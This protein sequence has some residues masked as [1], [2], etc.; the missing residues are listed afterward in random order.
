MVK[1]A[2]I[3]LSS[4]AGSNSP[5]TQSPVEVTLSEYSTDFAYVFKMEDVAAAPMTSEADTSHEASASSP[6]LRSPPHKGAP[7]PP[8]SGNLSLSAFLPQHFLLESTGSQMEGK[9]SMAEP[10]SYQVHLSLIHI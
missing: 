8:S 10:A 7:C 5:K 4:D 1:T 9:V 6:T 3:P 2:C